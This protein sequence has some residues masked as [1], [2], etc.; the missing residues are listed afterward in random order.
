[1]GYIIFLLFIFVSSAE[2]RPVSY[3]DGWTLMSRNNWETSRLH[4]HYSPTVNYSLGAVAEDY[5]NSERR[6][7]NLQLNNLLLRRNTSNSQANLYSMIELGVATDDSTEFN[8]ALS[9]AGDWETR[10]YFTSYSAS[11]QHAG[12]FD[13]GSFHQKGRVG[14]APYLANFG[15]IHTWLMLQ[16]EHHPEEDK[17]FRIAPVIRLFKNQ[18]LFEI[19][20]DSEK[21]FIFNFIYRH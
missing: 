17:E 8:K 15:S 18:F 13:N 11:I 19:G 2:A 3:P 10:R 21:D 1:M 7:F 9:F 4:L 20:L 12:A 16:A 6:D 14:I 5:R